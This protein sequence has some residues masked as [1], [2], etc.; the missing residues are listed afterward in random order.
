MQ[1]AAVQFKATPGDV[2]GS[3]RRCRAL[4]SQ[5]ARG[6]DLVVLPEMAAT[7]YIFEDRA[8]VAAVAEPAQGPT[9]DALAPIAR[10]HRCWLVAGFP[11]L[12][13]GDLFN[14]ALVI[15]PQ[16]VLAW[17]YRKTLL[18]EEDLHWATP[19]GS[20]YRAFETAGGRFGV[21]ICMDLNDDR[22]VAWL[23]EQRLDAI[24]FPTNWVHSD[25]V[26]VWRYWAWRLAGLDAALV[27]ANTWGS[28][29]CSRG[30]TRFSGRSTVLQRRTILAALPATGDGVIQASLSPPVSG[31]PGGPPRGEAKE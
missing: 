10:A 19:G 2:A 3:L 30:Q 23:L 29:R 27:A 5:A 14:S 21:G 6:A 15:D 20:G 17:V 22:F 11:E 16:G 7:G 9:L 18:Y 25:E 28:G 1:V 31:G 12:D 13:G 24:A 8:A 26:D 4:A